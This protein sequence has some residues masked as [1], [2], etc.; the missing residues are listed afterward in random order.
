M[1]ITL[2]CISPW[3]G[4]RP[5]TS[6][7]L[8]RMSSR[9]SLRAP[10]RAAT[11]AAESPGSSSASASAASSSSEEGSG[12]DFRPK[13][14]T[15]DEERE[16]SA[17]ESDEV[18]S[19]A[20]F[21]VV[22]S[23]GSSVGSPRAKPKKRKLARAG[24]V[25]ELQPAV[26]STVDSF[27][28]AEVSEFRTK[29]LEWYIANCRELPWRCSARYQ[30]GGECKHP[31]APPETQS[32][33]GAPYGV[34][35][36]EI[37]SQQTRLEVVV[38]YWKNWMEK[39][40]TVQALAS[41]TMEDVNEAWAGLG[42]YRRARFLHE[43]ANQVVSDFDGELPRS[44]E[45]LLKVKGIGKYTAGAVCSIAFSIPVPAVDGNVERVLSRTRPGIL[46]NR[47]PTAT[48]GA[49]AK[50]YEALATKL[51]ADI[52]CPG[53]LNQGLMELGA[54][55]CTPK[56]PL[57][58]ECPVQSLCG[59]YADAKAAKQDPATYV[60]RFPVKDLSRKTKSRDETVLVCC[61]RRMRKH[62]GD[63]KACEEY[64]LLQR[65]KDGLL[66]NMW[67]PPNVLLSAVEAKKNSSPGARAK[68][69]DGA[70]DTLLGRLGYKAKKLGRRRPA[71]E[72]QHVFSH[73]RQQLFVDCLFVEGSESTKDS[74]EVN[75]V[76]YR[77]L[78]EA[79]I[80]KSAVATQMRKVFAIALDADR[81]P[82]EHGKKRARA[83]KLRE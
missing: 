11:L 1:L 40:P 23:D 52:E 39:F 20:D 51:V 18:V 72:T 34:W 15:A 2:P 44:V 16:S 21:G 10:R 45:G 79:D 28:G 73:I 81:V 76:N 77:W 22:S 12:E 25:A 19:E 42:Y 64:L 47:N 14:L 54:T 65:P 57:C 74:G 26:D 9:Y 55:V 31:V 53:D 5:L 49:K 36:S 8:G 75:G 56:N 80:E 30:A 59:A 6:F 62:V 70:V 66:A 35:V 37:M 68:L 41:A 43:A 33:P 27:N 61:V 58:S 82:K 83:R 29:L 46:P 50:V 63:E 67:E 17:S 24:S 32:S 78:S 71:G 48:L 13:D 3:V 7:C 69:L 4:S 38:R 60:Q